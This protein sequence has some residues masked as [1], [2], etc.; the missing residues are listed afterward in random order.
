M[1]MYVWLDSFKEKSFQVLDEESLPNFL[2]RRI[3]GYVIVIGEKGK[4][5]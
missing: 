5:M 2:I 3:T 1:R 4:Y